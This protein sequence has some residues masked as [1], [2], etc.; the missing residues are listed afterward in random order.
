MPNTLL[1]CGFREMAVRGHW[2]TET[3]R[4]RV[5]AGPGLLRAPRPHLCLGKRVLEENP[6]GLRI[7]PPA[8]SSQTAA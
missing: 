4:R 1:T 6:P 7:L 3:S 8:T 2:E 5:R